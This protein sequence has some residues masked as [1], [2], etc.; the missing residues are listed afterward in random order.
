MNGFRN[1]TK[2][3]LTLAFLAIATG[4]WGAENVWNDATG[5]HKWGTPGNWSLERCPAGGITVTRKGFMLLF[6]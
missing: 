4:S 6:R 3:A 1:V 2:A 5:D